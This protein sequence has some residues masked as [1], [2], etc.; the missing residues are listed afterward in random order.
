MEQE[1]KIYTFAGLELCPGI[2]GISSGMP[3]T[4]I[5]PGS[6]SYGKTFGIKEGSTFFSLDNL[7][8]F[9]NRLPDG[10]RLPTQKEWKNIIT[11]KGDVR[12]GSIVNGNP[13]SHYA[14]ISVKLAQTGK[15]VNALMIFPDGETIR[16][17]FLGRVDANHQTPGFTENDVNVYTSQGAAVLYGLGHFDQLNGLW[18][19]GGF[20]GFYW[21]SN[22]IDE[23][24]AR[25]L[26]FDENYLY[27]DDSNDA[28]KSFHVVKLV[29]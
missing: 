3:V 23:D 25:G 24:D 29:R 26:Y 9:A 19:E 5:D 2:L 14:F 6:S 28:A 13:F 12:P 11:K 20:S 1:N 18:S 4:G 10:W 15:S 8:T 7:E 22:R 21:S 27:D 16:G 17:R